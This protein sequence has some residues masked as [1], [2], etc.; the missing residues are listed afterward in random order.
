MSL[1]FLQ[2]FNFIPLMA[3]EDM[4]F[5]FFVFANLAFRL[6]WQPI[7]L[8]VLDKNDMFGR[9]LLLNEHF[10][11]TFLQTSAVTYTVLQMP[12]FTFP[13]IRQ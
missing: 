3:S 9:G 10:C 1:T 13:I 8:R 6:P 2:N 4:I 11:K 12:I 5:D 7:K